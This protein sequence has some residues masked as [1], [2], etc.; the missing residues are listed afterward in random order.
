M[1]TKTDLFDNKLGEWGN[2]N[3]RGFRT[4]S[5]CMF[6]QAGQMGM[7]IKHELLGDV[8]VEVMSYSRDKE[9]GLAVEMLKTG[10]YTGGL[11]ARY[12]LPSFLRHTVRKVPLVGLRHSWRRARPFRWPSSSPDLRCRAPSRRG[13]RTTRRAPRDDTENRRPWCLV[14]SRCEGETEESVGSLRTLHVV[15]KLHVQHVRPCTTYQ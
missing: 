2:E 9:Y 14:T 3:T 15:G 10:L 12:S 6:G 8:F 11:P 1:L 4:Q 13:P 5:E 7:G